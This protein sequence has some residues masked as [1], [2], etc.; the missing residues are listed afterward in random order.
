MSTQRT[1][2]ILLDTDQEA[3]KQLSEL[4]DA[5]HSACNQIVPEVIASRCWNR[6]ALHRLVYI[7]MRSVSPLGSQ[8]ICNAIFSVCKAYKAK[9][10]LPKE[11]VP[12][13]VFHKGK[14]VHFDKRTYCIKGESISLYTLN[15]RIKVRMKWGPHQKAYFSR[16]VPKEGELICKKGK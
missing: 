9:A 8:M 12:K 5:Y 4:Q 1:I 6:V 3:K 13:I 7:K 14:S 16:G 10:I 15:K 2:S 11:E